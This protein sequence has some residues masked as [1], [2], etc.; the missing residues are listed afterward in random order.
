MKPIDL[1]AASLLLFAQRLNKHNA[2]SKYT[3]TCIRNGR[4]MN[5]SV[6]DFMEAPQPGN[7]TYEMRFADVELGRGLIRNLLTVQ[8][9]I[10]DQ[11]AKFGPVRAPSR[12]R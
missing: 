10:Q 1:F 8:K 9:V 11:P 12:V 7:F 4:P 2:R 5:Q 3:A 6:V